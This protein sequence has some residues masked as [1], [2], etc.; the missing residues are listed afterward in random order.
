MNLKRSNRAIRL[1][2]ERILEKRKAF[3]YSDKTLF[4]NTYEYYVVDYK[5]II[6]SKVHFFQV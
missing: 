5:I 1:E 2:K 3:D 6:R 4:N